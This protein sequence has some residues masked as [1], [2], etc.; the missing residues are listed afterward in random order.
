MIK[1]PITV[2]LEQAVYG[3]FPF[4]D[5]GYAVLAHSAGCRSEWIAE[6]RTACQ[7]CGEPPAGQFPAE[8]LFALRLHS[9][10]WTIVGVHP[11]GCD[12][13]G[14]PGALAFHA[15]FMSRWAYRWID[16]DPFAFA[17]ALR[18]DWTAADKDRQL[19]AVTWSAATRSRAAASI[20]D[21]GDDP[22]LAQIVAALSQ[23]RRV[24][25]QSTEPIDGLARSIWSALPRSIRRR[26]TVA[27]WA[28]DNANQ[29]DLVGVPK[30]AG[31]ALNPADLVFALEHA[32]R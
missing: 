15:L 28:F 26:A 27:T 11:Q 3:S 12:D 6:L 17:G 13:Q 5:R 19:T 21:D 10:P 4:W 29:F 32:G 31:V 2:R 30:L 22:R 14:R 24:V 18:R 9:G 25:V 16:A 7:R 20:S 1:L 23:G 8:S